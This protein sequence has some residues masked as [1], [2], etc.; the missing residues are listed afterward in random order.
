MNKYCLLVLLFF[1]TVVASAQER[2]I[3]GTLTDR[4]THEAVTQTTVQLLKSDSTFVGGSISN[5]KGE[6]ALTAPADGSYL[7]KVS[8]VGY[9]TYYKKLQITDGKNL[10]L[11]NIVMNA[12][13]IMLKGATVTGQAVKVTVREDTFVYNSAAFRTPEGSTIEE[14]VKRLPGAQISDDG[15]ITING[16]EVKKILIDGKEFMTGDTQTALKNLPTSIVDKIK[17]YDQRSDLARVSGIDDG[18]DQTVLDFGIKKGMNKGVF[19]NIDLAQG[20]QSRYAD[21][22]MGAYFK[23]EYRVMLFANANNTN[24][25]GFP[26]GGGRGNFGH[27]RDGLNATKMLGT[28]FNYEKKD[29]LKIDWSVRWNHSDGDVQSRVATENFVSTAGSFSNSL[30][31]SY[32]RSNKWNARGRLEWQPDSLTNIMFRPTFS[33]STSD[34]TSTSISGTYND[35]PYNYVAD[36]LLASSIAQMAA[37]S[38]MVNSRS[39]NSISIPKSKRQAECCN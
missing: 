7:L 5:E 22:L 30:N 25:M 32:S 18:D 23:D 19:S 38:L 39:L 11:G 34:G 35:N 15:K 2:K 36:P 8:S 1:V 33:Y 31:Q 26:G 17:A 10:A 4:D 6:F 9:L 27:N 13:A 20:T 12:D 37:D 14:L 28:N 29:K 21:R 16:K 24:D 3:S